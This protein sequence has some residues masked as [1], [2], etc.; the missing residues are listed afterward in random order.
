MTRGRTLALVVILLECMLIVISVVSLLTSPD[1]RFYYYGY[2]AMYLVLIF[3]NAIFLIHTQRY[4]SLAEKSDKQLTRLDLFIIV[5]I[6][7]MMCWG[8]V[9]TLIDQKLYGQL[10]A[11]MINMIAC[12]AIYTLDTKRILIPYIFSLAVLAI[13]LPFLQTSI[14]LLV[15]HYVNLCITNMTYASIKKE[16]YYCH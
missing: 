4:Q 8:A 11:F 3:L 6:T 14:D 13:G 9:V 10:M 7:L 1:N 5:Y 16:P 12:S 2:I 15:G